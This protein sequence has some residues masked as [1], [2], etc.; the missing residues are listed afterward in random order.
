MGVA[1]GS[2]V[3]RGVGRGDDDVEVGELSND[4]AGL[5][6]P[7][8]LVSAVGGVTAGVSVAADVTGVGDVTGVEVAADVSVA[9]A[10]TASSGAR[11]LIGEGILEAARNRE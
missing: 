6:I 10:R 9:R 3:L 4:G 2:A 7:V 5:G 8:E 11:R 1:A